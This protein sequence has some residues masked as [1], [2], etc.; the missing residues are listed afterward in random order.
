[1]RIRI[2]TLTT[3]ILLAAAARLV[4]HPPNFA[5]I[6]GIALFGGA[7]F[8]DR[9]QAFL[10]PLLAMFLSDLVLGFHNQMTLVYLCFAATVLIGRSLQQNRSVGRVAGAA[11]A[12]SVLFFVVTNFGVWLTGGLYPHTASGLTACYIAA[13]PFFQT[14]LMGDAFYTV[15]LFS[16]FALAERYFPV[17]RR[18][19]LAL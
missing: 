9:R 4:P 3:L 8:I 6:M 18:P 5:P 12:S 19:A 2:V 11:F 17:L 13:L 10:V 1:M 16:G 7:T 15:V 14:T